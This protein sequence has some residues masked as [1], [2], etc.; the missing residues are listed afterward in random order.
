MLLAAPAVV[1]MA[2]RLER[3]WPVRSLVSYLAFAGTGA[4]AVALVLQ[5]LQVARTQKERDFFTP[6]RGCCGLLVA[7]SVGLRHAYPLD[8]IP[9]VPRAWGL[10]CQ[11][12]PFAIVAT[13]VVC[14]VLG[15][16]W[17]LPEWPF[18]PSALFF[19]WLYL[20][21]PHA[22]AHGDHSPDFCFANF[23]PVP[24]RPLAAAVGAMTHSLALMAA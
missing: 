9:H 7:L 23:F 3:L 19:A 10:Q 16:K 18:A 4:G 5:I 22:K 13:A 17:L 2:Q 1:L 12:L 21:T 20:A 8:A 14:G 6:V 24:A 15:P 11:H